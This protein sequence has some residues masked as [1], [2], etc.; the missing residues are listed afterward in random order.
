MAEKTLRDYMILPGAD[1]WTQNIRLLYHGRVEKGTG[2]PIKR[3]K[4]WAA[5]AEDM[6]PNEIN[7]YTEKDFQ[8][9]GIGSTNRMSKRGALHKLEA[10]IFKQEGYHFVT[11]NGQLTKENGTVKAAITGTAY[12]IDLDVERSRPSDA[13]STSVFL[14]YTCPAEYQVD[15]NMILFS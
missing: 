15:K 9:V 2:E 7:V 8:I 1:E 11:A 13:K 5:N 14:E 4:A 6:F 12:K 10:E 3:I